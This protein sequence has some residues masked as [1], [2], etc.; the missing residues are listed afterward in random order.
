MPVAV[1]GSE[2]RIVAVRGAVLD[3]A[4]GAGPLPAIGD[5]LAID[6]GGGEP[7]PA[8]V[9]AHLDEHTVRSIALRSTS[10]L[11]RGLRVQATGGPILVPV[12]DAVR[13]RLLDVI[14]AI[15]D[16]GPALPSDVPRRPIHRAPPPLAQQSAT[17]DLF[18]TG[19]KVV[20]LLTPLVQGGKE[21]GRAHV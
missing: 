11:A 4:F 19:I 9:Q 6:G 2:G 17:T 21:I 1:A 18:S 5:A 8:E 16:Q 13:G 15:G 7:L 3:V 14:G 10:G 12:G 20:D